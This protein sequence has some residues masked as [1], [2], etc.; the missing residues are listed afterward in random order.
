MKPE[1]STLVPCV[2]RR[3]H[4]KRGWTSSHDVVSLGGNLTQLGSNRIFRPGIE[5]RR[6]NM[7]NLGLGLILQSPFF[8]LLSVSQK[9]ILNPFLFGCRYYAIV[10][11]VG[12]QRD[13]PLAWLARV[14]TRMN[15]V[16]YF[17]PDREL[18]F[19]TSRV[20]KPTKHT[21]RQQMG[22]PSLHY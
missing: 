18:M 13:G 17:Y 21:K 16:T 8:P 9:K 15:C 2:S 3:C 20:K 22:Q 10:H 1:A 5:S 7:H 6:G 19:V 12:I 11:A 4:Y 14:L